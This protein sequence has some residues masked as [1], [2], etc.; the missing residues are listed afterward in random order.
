M[1]YTERDKRPAI[2]ESDLRRYT[3]IAKVPLAR[4]WLLR[5]LRSQ[6]RRLTEAEGAEREQARERF[7]GL[8]REMREMGMGGKRHG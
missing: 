8:R 4:R 1:E 7:E 3:G 5:R 6:M 2:S